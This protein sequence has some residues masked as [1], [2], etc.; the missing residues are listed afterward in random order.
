MEIRQ[1]MSSMWYTLL[2]LLVYLGIQAFLLAPRPENL[3]YSEFKTLLRA[4][5]VSDLV[6]YKD[7]IQGTLAPTGLDK[8]LPKQKIEELKRRGNGAHRFATTRVDDSGLVP[9][10]E[11]LHVQFSGQPE[12][13]WLQALLSWLVPMAIFFGIWIFF[14]RRMNTQG[15]LMTIGKSKARVYVERDTGVSF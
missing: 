7:T 6:L 9:A 1:R 15:T 3:S 10:L 8:I 13:T 5:K 2:A 12:S 14:F 11:N 4:G